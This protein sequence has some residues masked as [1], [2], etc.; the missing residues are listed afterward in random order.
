MNDECLHKTILVVEDELPLQNAIRRKLE[1]SGFDVVTA[2]NVEQAR[3][4]LSTAPNIDAVWL[5]HYLLGK[6]NGLDLVFTCKA[7][8]SAHS[9]IPIFL[10]SNTASAD[11]V[12][13][14]LTLGVN[15]Y[16]VKAERRLG[17]IIEDLKTELG[18]GQEH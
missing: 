11:K 2:R 12:Q 13:A 3:E 9:T 10:V 1:K 6:Q 7:E 4:Q 17:D 18:C 16:Y 14:Y 15:K 8:G 5:D